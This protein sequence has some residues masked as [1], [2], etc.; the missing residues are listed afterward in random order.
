MAGARVE[1]AGLMSGEDPG[2]LLFALGV[3]NPEAL[4]LV[5]DVFCSVK[6]RWW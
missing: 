3:E 2:N 1:A 5:L 6:L 4:V